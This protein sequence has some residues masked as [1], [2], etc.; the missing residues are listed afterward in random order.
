[1]K[2]KSLKKCHNSV[3]KNVIVQLEKSHDSVSKISHSSIRKKSQF[4]K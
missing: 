3:N 2:I 1:M 4:G